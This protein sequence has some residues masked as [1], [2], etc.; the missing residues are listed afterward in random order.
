[1]LASRTTQSSYTIEFHPRTIDLGSSTSI[2]PCRGSWFRGFLAQSQGDRISRD[3]EWRVSI[4]CNSRYVIFLHAILLRN[5]SLA[6]YAVQIHPG[7][8]E[9]WFWLAEA[10]GGFENNEF[11]DLND[12]NRTDV[13][14][15]L[16]KGLQFDPTDGLR[17]RLMGDLLR[18]ADP[19]A[20][21]DAYLQSCF[22]GDPG[23]NGC[24]RAGQIAEQVGE[25]ESAIHYYR[26]SAW[27]GALNRADELEARLTNPTPTLDQ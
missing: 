27:G 23:S 22:N 1:M 20:A 14:T 17:W 15:Y 25:I 18:S 11:Q 7:I 6:E 26:Y 16:R 21:I 2:L 24:W 9:G 5:I 13:I 12:T 8:A 3:Y 4:H 10:T 19:Q